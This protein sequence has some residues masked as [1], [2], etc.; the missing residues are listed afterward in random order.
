MFYTEVIL[1]IL[2]SMLEVRTFYY[3]VTDMDGVTDWW[4]RAFGLT[5]H[6]RSA[7]YS[8]FKLENV[9]VGFVLNDWGET[10]DGNRGALMLNVVPEQERDVLIEKIVSLGGTITLDNRNS[11]LKSVVVEDP[12]G[13]EYEIGSLTHD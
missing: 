13:N 12:F 3:K 1:C 8:E 4:M 6:K 5:P 7:S 9:R 10:Y 2:N 11:D